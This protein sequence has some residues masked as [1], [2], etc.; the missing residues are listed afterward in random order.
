[1]SE[2]NA[3]VGVVQLKR[4]D[5]LLRKRNEVAKQYNAMLSS[6]E[7]AMP[8][9]IV[10][11]TTRMSWFVYVVRFVHGI[12][13]GR[14]INDLAAT[15]IPARPYFTPIHLQPFYRERFGFKPGDFPEAEAAGQSIIALPFHTNMKVEEIE[16]VRKA[17]KDVLTRAKDQG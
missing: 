15:G 12:D 13:R 11:T 2:L 10:P 8:L 3:S 9:T 16:V 5:E 14:I 17:L 1:M 6:L 7:D 4:L